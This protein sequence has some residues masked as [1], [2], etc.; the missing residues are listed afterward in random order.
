MVSRNGTA[1]TRATNRYR[2]ESFFGPDPYIGLFEGVPRRT[3]KFRFWLLVSESGPVFY[4]STMR[5]EA[6]EVPRYEYVERRPGYTRVPRYTVI[7]DNGKPRCLHIDGV[8]VWKDA[9]YTGDGHPITSPNV[10]PDPG[11]EKNT[12]EGSDELRRLAPDGVYYPYNLDPKK[13]DVR[14]VRYNGELYSMKV[15]PGK[16]A[17]VTH[18]VPLGAM[19]LFAKYAETGETLCVQRADLPC[20]FCGVNTTEP[21]GPLPRVNGIKESPGF[22]TYNYMKRSG[23]LFRTETF[24]YHFYYSTTYRVLKLLGDHY[25]EVDNDCRVY[26]FTEVGPDHFSKH[27]TVESVPGCTATPLYEYQGQKSKYIELRYSK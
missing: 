3:Q 2:A 10:K 6:T 20:F 4:L 23:G 18:L 21:N 11:V 19:K 25:M 26:Q 12:Y 16:G 15:P 24:P 9:Q 27:W 17:K 1:N 8:L 7:W 14:M 22:D 5:Q 13:S